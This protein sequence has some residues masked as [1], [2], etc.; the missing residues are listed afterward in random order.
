MEIDF[1]EKQN[2]LKKTMESGS[3][4]ILIEVNTPGKKRDFSSAASILKDMESAAEQVDSISAGLAVTDKLESEDSW[5]VADFANELSSST[6]DKHV[7]FVSGKNSTLE[8]IKDTIERC[9]A[10]GFPN[11]VAVTGEGVSGETV[12][13]AAKRHYVDSVHTLNLIQ[14]MPPF[15]YPGCVVSPFKYTVSDIFPQYYKFMKKLKQGA[16]F[17][18]SQS[19][20]DMMKYQE[21]RWYLE[22]REAHLPTV[23]RLTLLTPESVEN[24]YAGKSPGMHVS[25][26]LY[27]I[28]NKEARYGSKQFASAQWRRIQIQAAGCRLLGYSGLQIS[29]INR[30][31]H[32]STVCNKIIEAIREFSSFE[33]WKQTYLSHLARAEMAPYPHRFYIFNNLFTCL[34]PQ[35]PIMNS[36]R[37]PAGNVFE[38]LKFKLCHLLFS[39]ANRHHPGEHKLSKKILAGCKGCSYCRLPMTHYICPKT[40]PKGLANGPCGGTQSNGNCEFE[41]KECIHGKRFR[42]AVWQKEIDILEERYIKPIE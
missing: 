32:V 37:L 7:L 16:N 28:L 18:I 8:S 10:S 2:R 25:A 21:L 3:F 26:D 4:F 13:E 24:I 39:K 40:C 20:W 31:E 15:F 29:G 42:I 27:K 33:D 30:P 6:R 19:G 34:Y 5:N 36:P 22:M 1:A 23:A 17:L 35:T 9:K 11:I 38:R 41:K 12:K 14:S